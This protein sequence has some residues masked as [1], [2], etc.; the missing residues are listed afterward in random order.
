MFPDQLK[1]ADASP[2]IKKGN[3]MVKPT[4]DQR[5]SYPRFQKFMRALFI[6]K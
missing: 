3:I 6:T 4:I 1:N 5:V 2:L